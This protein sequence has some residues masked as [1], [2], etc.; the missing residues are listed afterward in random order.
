MYLLDLILALP[1]LLEQVLTYFFFS[2]SL[3]MQIRS[4]AYY[5]EFLFNRK[6]KCFLTDVILLVPADDTKF[7]G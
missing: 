6:L 5:K 7:L 1:E 4:S 3:S 2:K